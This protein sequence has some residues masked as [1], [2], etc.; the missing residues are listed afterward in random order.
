MELG[1]F[2]DFFGCL[3]WADKSLESSPVKE[4][5]HPAEKEEGRESFS[6]V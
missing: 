3:L 4:N 6:Y 5:L 2:A 1:L